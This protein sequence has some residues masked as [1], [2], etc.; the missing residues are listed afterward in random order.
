MTEQRQKQLVI[1]SALTWLMFTGPVTY[2]N[3]AIT[4][5]GWGGA[6][7]YRCVNDWLSIQC[8]METSRGDMLLHYVTDHMCCRD[9][10]TWRV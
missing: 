9:E 2:I 6:L 4:P 3:N 5:R 1:F 7:T 8:T 10:G